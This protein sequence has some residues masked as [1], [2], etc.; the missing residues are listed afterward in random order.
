MGCSLLLAG[1]TVDHLLDRCP[2]PDV[3]LAGSKNIQALKLHY[4]KWAALL[5]GLRQQLGLSSGD[6]PDVDLVDCT[7]VLRPVA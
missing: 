3:G 7:I 4:G 1:R 5:A 2:D 6:R